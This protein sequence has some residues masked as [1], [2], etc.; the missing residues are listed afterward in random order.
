MFKK[1]FKI[2]KIKG[3]TNAYFVYKFD[4]FFSNRRIFLPT[5][6]FTAL[7][8]V[9]VDNTNNSFVFSAKEIVPAATFN[10]ILK[11]QLDEPN[12]MEKFLPIPYE[13]VLKAL[14][15]EALVEHDKQKADNFDSSFEVFQVYQ[16]NE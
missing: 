14:T 11:I 8:P 16:R 2:N 13:L 4:D 3:V 10:Y 9:V 6:N 12:Q 7:N 15:P 1:Y 5:N